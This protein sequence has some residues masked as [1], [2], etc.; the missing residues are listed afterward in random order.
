M[1]MEHSV[2][3]LQLQHETTKSIIDEQRNLFLEMF[4]RVASKNEYKLLKV[5]WKSLSYQIRFNFLMNSG[6]NPLR[7]NF[8][9]ITNRFFL[10]RWLIFRLSLLSIYC[11]NTLL[12]RVVELY[13]DRFSWPREDS[14]STLFSHH[15][16]SGS[17]DGAWSVQYS[18]QSCLLF[19]LRHSS[20]LAHRYTAYSIGQSMALRYLADEFCRWK[21]NC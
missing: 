20:I 17:K 4:D 21:G 12:K 15:F 8:D 19:M 7:N 5:T 1:R 6:D 11:Q 3:S 9:K 13:L 10:G 2:A 18:V 16:F 14:K